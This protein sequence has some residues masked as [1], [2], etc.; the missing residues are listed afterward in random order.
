VPVDPEPRYREAPSAIPRAVRWYSRA[1]QAR[2]PVLPDGCMDLIWMHG[3]LVVA[4]PDTTA[5]ITT[6]CPGARYAAVRFA[7]GTAPAYLGLPAVELRDQ[8]PPLADLLPDAQ[9]RALNEAVAEARDPAMAIE[10]R[11]VPHLR[12]GSPDPMAGA[13]AAR[14]EA[15]ARVGPTAAEIGLSERQFRRRC[16]EAFGYPAKTL[17][18]ILRMH[19]ALEVARSGTPLARVAAET[20]YAD[21]AHLSREVKALAG[22]PPSVLLG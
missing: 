9:A 19:R 2:R 21:Q 22:A 1:E 16:L 13:V 6:L 8:H 7:P 18:R 20:G 14:L 12:T 3:E 4:G 17:A 11:V 15:G 10:E 5:R